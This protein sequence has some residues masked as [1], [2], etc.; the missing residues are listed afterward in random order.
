MATRHLTLSALVTALVLTPAVAAGHGESEPGP[1]GGVI[2]MPSAF[3]VEA[4]AGEEALR[5]FLLDME[6]KHPQTDD[7]RVEPVVHQ[8][9]RRV[10]LQCRAE[11]EAFVCPLPDGLS[12][13][14]GTLVVE[15]A[16]ADAPPGRAEYELPLV[17]PSDDG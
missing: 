13:E 4:K 3:H 1:H 10:P 6:F 15:A 11:E 17:P 2:R 16:R 12:L 9:D 7:S 5:L 14:R 8:G